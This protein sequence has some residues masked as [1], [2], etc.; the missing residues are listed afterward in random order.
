VNRRV[1][2]VTTIVVLGLGLRV[3]LAAAPVIP[4]RQPLAEFPRQLGRW[5]AVSDEAI[6]ADTLAVLKADDYLVRTY[7]GK[8]GEPAALFI[9][10][11]RAQHAGESMHSP[12]NC[13]PGSGWQPVQNDRV[14]LGTDARGQPIWVNRYVV[15]KGGQRALALYWY[16]ENGRTIA[17]EYWGK[18]YM[19]WDTFRTGRRDGAIVRI[20]VPMATT[21]DAT[22]ALNTALDLART[23]SPYLSRFV[24]N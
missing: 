19:V 20:S 12:K 10:Y 23:S 4:P 16:Q 13:M 21:D 11:Y 5:A 8:G 3:W 6:D 9:A 24:P 15:A 7:R 14:S 17:S 2:M 18:I 22:T 1:L